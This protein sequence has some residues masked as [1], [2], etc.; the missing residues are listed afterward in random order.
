MI[1]QLI[2]LIALLPLISCGE[3]SENNNHDYGYGYDEY[4]H[5]TNVRVQQRST[6]YLL[7]IELAA[8]AYIETQECMNMYADGPMV[9][10]VESSDDIDSGTENNYE[11]Y[12]YFDTM[13]IVVSD[14][15]LIAGLDVILKHEY[16]HYILYN[17]GYSD[18]NETYHGLYYFNT[19]T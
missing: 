9:V 11:G 4:D 10:V 16:I 12:F 14:D 8:Q 7:P 1:K 5:E 18:P 6:E 15:F 17:N 19:C 3:M 2:F 13:L